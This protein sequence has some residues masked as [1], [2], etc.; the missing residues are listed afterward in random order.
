MKICPKC[1]KEYADDSLNFCLDD[2][3][4]LSV[5]EASP[6]PQPVAATVPAEPPAGKSKRTVFIVLGIL[7]GV[8]FLCTLG[9]FGV[10]TIQQIY[11]KNSNTTTTG[12]TQSEKEIDS[13][14]TSEDGRKLV[15][16]INFEDW[17]VENSGDITASHINGKLVLNTRQEFYY[18]L[19]SQGLVN[20]NATVRVSAT[21]MDSQTTPF[22]YGL[23]VFSDPNSIAEN[24]YSFVI[25]ADKKDF[26]IVRHLNRTENVIVDWKKSN[27]IK[28]GESENLL[29]VRSNMDKVFFFIN[30]VQVYAIREFDG[31]L[32]G[33]TGIYTS[34][35]AHIGF[36]NLEYFK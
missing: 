36:S 33:V 4:L 1:K 8:G 2:G 28:S 25:R 31:K 15:I 20:R 23:V 18:I 17:K 27:A 34:G 21:R 30:D 7:L 10:V 9:A 24:D 5:Y 3:S 32:D 26:R 11:Y 12:S 35:T 19:L 16:S 14:P 6:T 22:G 29:E 13:L